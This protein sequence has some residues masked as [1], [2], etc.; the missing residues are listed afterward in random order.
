MSRRFTVQ[1][2][3]QREIADIY[4]HLEGLRPSLGDRF[5]DALEVSFGYIRQFPFGYQVRRGHYRH[6]M[7]EG[8]DY[9]V[10]FV[11][12]GKDIYVYQVRHTSRRPIRA[13]GP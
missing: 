10:V 13:F 5:V 4:D 3:A 7:I 2:E 9:R 12:D 11:V 1:P 8:F 6:A